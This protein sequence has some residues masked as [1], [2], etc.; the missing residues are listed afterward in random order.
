[1][2]LR[3]DKIQDFT[4]QERQFPVSI[5]ASPVFEL[6]L[7]LFVFTSERKILTSDYERGSVFIETFESHASKKL[8]ETMSKLTACGGLWLALIGDAHEIEA[9]SVKSFLAHLERMEPVALRELVARNTGINERHGASAELIRRAAE[10]EVGAIDELFADRDSDAE[11]LMRLPIADSARVVIDTIRMFHG[12]VFVHLEDHTAVLQRDANEKQAL[13]ATLPADQFVEAATGGVT[14]T[15]QPSVSGVVLIPSVVI[16]PW[17][18]I[19]EHGTLRIFCYG[20]ADASLVDDDA[21]PAFLVDLFKALGDERRL[22]ILRILAEGDTE[23]KTLTEHLDLAKSTTHHH[24]RILRTAGLVRVIVDDHEKR[25][26]IRK[27][28]LSQAGPIL[29]NFVLSRQIPE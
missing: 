27:E 15:M 3:G 11:W 20:V 16:R 24:L 13:A 19:T 8:V 6:L 26:G 12:E 2:S 18:V 25:Y 1:M 23:L 17:A 21:P 9:K 5:V 22:R 10:G 29:E 4:S 28:A 7:T 14:F